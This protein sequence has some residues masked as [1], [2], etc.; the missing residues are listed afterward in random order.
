MKK[1]LLAAFVLL[2][3]VSATQAQLNNN[4]IDYTK[5]YYKFKVG[6]DTLCRITQPVLA[7]AGLGNVPAQNFQLWRN[8]KEVRIYTSVATGALGAND[9]IE[10]WG[11]MNDGKPDKTLYNNPDQQLD[12][13]YSLFSD[14]ATFFLTVNATGNNLR[15]TQTDNPVGTNTLPADDYFMRRVEVHFRDGLNRGKYELL[16][17]AIYSSAF[18]Q[19]EGWLSRG[20]AACC[21]LSRPITNLNKYATGPAN[22]VMFTVAAYGASRLYTR[23]LIARFYSTQVLPSPSP[24]PY[25][26]YRR[27][28]VRNLPLSLLQS[29]T[30]LPVSIGIANS[31]NAANDGI[32]VASFSVT[33]PAT[34][35]FNNESNFYFELQPSANPN[36]NFIII[37]NFSATLP[38]VLYDITNG[39][40][41]IGDVASTP[42]QVKFALPASSVVRKF[43]LM[44]T[45][46]GN[47]NN[48]GTLT[49]KSFINFANSA[50]QGDYLIISNS[51]L[52]NN[53]SGI[54]YVDQY[55]Q[56]RSAATGGGYNAKIVDIDELTDQFGFGINKHP[57]AIRDFIRYANQQFTVKPKSVLLIGRGVAYEDALVVNPNYTYQP[58]PDIEKLNLV[59]TF[60]WPASDVLLACEPG[61]QAPLI[62]IG[63]ISAINGDEVK[64]YLEKIQE[65]EQVQ[66]SGIQTVNEKAWMKN[67][68]HISG[69]KD[70][71][72]TG[73]FIGHL[74]RYKDIAEDTL[75]GAH[76]ETFAKSGSGTVQEANS[77][78]IDQL[79]AEGISLISYF[80]HSSAN[81]LAFNLSN[82]ETYQN[83]GKYPFFNVSG[84]SAGNFFAY[85]ASRLAGSLSLSEKYVLSPQKGSIGFLADTHFGIEPFLNFY[86]TNFYNEFCKKNYGGTIGDHMRK[87]NQIISANP[88]LDF[89]TRIHL[90]ELTL[91]GDPALR[92]NYHP[93]P[94]Y[95]IEEQ[96]IRVSPSIISVADNS[97]NVNVKILNIGRAIN[98]SI[99]IT[100]KRKLPNDTIQVLYNAKRPAIK[101]E[102]TLAFTI[103][104]NPTTD[105]GANKIIV[106]IDTENKVAEISETNNTAE[107]EFFI[108]E[109]EV[110]PVYPYNFSI[111]NQQNITYTASTANPLVG[112]RQFTM[113]VD[114]TELFNSPFKKAYTANGTGGV[115]EF[116]PT[117]ITFTDSIVYYWRTAIIQPGN[118]NVIWNTSSFVY[119]AAGAKGWS[120][121]HLYQ[122]LKSSYTSI[123]LDSASRKF[124]FVPRTS[125]IVSNSGTF[126]NSLSQ[127]GEYNLQINGAQYI[128]G[129]CNGRGLIFYLFNP[130]SLDPI[131]NSPG[132]R[133]GS[134]APCGQSTIYNY[135]F[136]S[137][138]ATARK[139]IIDFMDSIPAGYYVVV[140]STYANPAA[141]PSVAWPFVPEWVAD[142]PAGTTLRDKLYTAG[143]TDIDSFY[144]ARCWAF[145]YKKNDPLFTP[146]FA[147]SQ[148]VFD[149]LS[150]EFNI[151][152]R[153]AE[154]TVASPLFG[155]AKKWDMLR[156]RGN[157]VENPTADVTSVDVY[158]IN[159]AGTST[160]IKNI[161]NVGDTSIGFIDANTYPYLQLK[162]NSS[163]FSVATPHQLRYWMVDGQAVP[164]GLVAPNILYQ[165]KDTME[166][167]EL[168][169]FKVAFKNISPSAF[170]SAMKIKMTI[171]NNEGIISNIAVPKGKVL[172]AGDTLVVQ[173][174]INSKIYP[175]NNTLFVDVNPN[176][177]QLEQSHFNNVLYKAFYVRPD[178]F[179]PLLDVTFDGIHILNKDIVSAK[180]HIY[181]KLKDDSR[182]MAL[183]D[184]GLLK[185]QVIYP[186]RSVR[187]FN[188]GDTMRFNPANLSAGENAASIDFTPFFTEDGDYELIVTG[189]DVVGNKAGEIEY[190]VQF[191][192]INK[193]MISNMLNYPNPFTTSTAFVF[194]LTGSEVPQNLRIQILTISGKVVREITKDELGPIR[195]GKN[196]TEYKWDGT[197][198]YGQKLANGVYLYRVITNL[199][200]QSL[201]KYKSK[202]DKT[203][204]FFNNGYG[205]MVLI[206]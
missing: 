205:K 106:A 188:F 138:D 41:Y 176:N 23:D 60:G 64:G 20:I 91:H 189:K 156:W 63:R 94:D 152:G 11:E 8:G 38:P 103:N 112:Q 68:V 171:T 58:R 194:T 178:N 56:Y 161:K 90:E 44:A 25:N 72:E 136:D 22:S 111:I 162:L 85:D 89:Y 39:R 42:G 135:E 77:A 32:G 131:Q 92:I 50:N 14:T 141:F 113:E 9:F 76:V 109:D 165:M 195:I 173:H 203:D 122:H 169:D 73:V 185:V 107:K 71:I 133:W 47:L 27:D 204:K 120:Q 83:K 147:L 155:P 198:M 134:I 117:N 139:K 144:R 192:V 202:G 67:M 54:N 45:D 181:I 146:K 98:D 95:V 153:A 180:P 49:N 167:G 2:I 34:F 46:A 158:G 28:T 197:D 78:R 143:F 51:R 200:G 127:E 182:F 53:G 110:R 4:W 82:P 6:K 116:K 168:I 124:N 43:N 48:I 142:G 123:K 13:K 190:R 59:P 62:P 164:E 115:V 199:N 206:R 137:K 119:V 30:G 15:Y 17:E 187:R 129:G 172:V 128:E 174:K 52:Y 74:N 97:F 121:S 99:R 148:G 84:C 57:V 100:V 55:R 79:M 157:S 10:F 19:G 101:Y 87:V 88:N 80:G 183:G 29:N 18:E 132:G 40:R 114:T 160:L 145:V 3:A 93:K 21:P 7:A 16:G 69:G 26:N 70:S 105:K 66:K 177:D 151:F 104:I 149:K 125:A 37:T 126:P 186:D 159:N 170:D 61:T 1:F 65:Y 184:T 163:D 36:G 35:N 140:K 5:T 175:G 191:N 166:Q 96:L 193:A 86:N 196:I 179:N 108:F 12:D 118:T 24:M 150:F 130:A 31:S 154:G 102:D 33:Y 75:F 81:T 201:D